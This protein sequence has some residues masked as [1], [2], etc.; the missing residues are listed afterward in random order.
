M[1]SRNKTIPNKTISDYK[2]PIVNPS[3][4]LLVLL[5]NHS[6]FEGFQ[7]KLVAKCCRIVRKSV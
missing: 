2:P 1:H 6:L 4:K 3:K 5:D 7:N